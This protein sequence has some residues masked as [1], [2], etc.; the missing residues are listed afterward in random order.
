[1]IGNLK[2]N[3]RVNLDFLIEGDDFLVKCDYE[4]LIEYIKTKM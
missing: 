3:N 2:Y 1:M 4:G